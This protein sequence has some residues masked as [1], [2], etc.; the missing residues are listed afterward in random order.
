MTLRQAKQTKYNNSVSVQSTYL[1]KKWCRSAAEKKR[2]LQK[3]ELG[4]FVLSMFY[5]K[6]SAQSISSW[7]TL[8]LKSRFRLIYDFTRILEVKSKKKR[9]CFDKANYDFHNF[10][11]VGREIRNLRKVSYVTGCSEKDFH[12][13]IFT[14]LQ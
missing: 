8:S 14:V 4:S 9:R 13:I 1:E 10:Q 12:Q 2:N 6:L 7:F 5:K 11:S 3:S